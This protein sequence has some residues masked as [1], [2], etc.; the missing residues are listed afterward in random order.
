MQILFTGGSSF[1]GYWF[2]K[3]L[4]EAG[5]QVTAIFRK[6]L[7]E[8]TGTRGERVRELSSFCTPLTGVSFGSEKMLELL[9]CGSWDLLCHHAADVTNYKSPEFDSI[10]ALSNNAHNIQQLL[11][12]LLE[13]GCSHVVLTGSV[14]E[15]REGA[16]A[17]ALGAFS[18]Y[19]LSKGLTYDLFNFYCKKEGIH[20]GKFVI[21]NPFG[22]LE[23][24]RYTSFIVQQ[25]L[26]GKKARCDFP[27]YVRDN[28]HVSLL[29]KAYAH[30]VSNFAINQAPLRVSPSGYPESQGA[31]TLRFAKEIGSRLNIVCPVDFVDE[32]PFPEP[33]VR[34][35]TD[36]CDAKLLQWNEKNA[37]DELATFY[38]R[39]F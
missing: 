2:I 39:S 15:Q 8:Y 14:F 16:G 35:N 24:M 17:S 9:R 19:G 5:H 20:L 1:T 4:Y 6:E 3:A 7:E 13:G 29:A 21:P 25:W 10:S 18:P 22:P 26:K 38:Q 30:Y 36:R 32:H 27:N 28:I 12:A 33:A 37:W 34:I 23:E 31:F 11:P